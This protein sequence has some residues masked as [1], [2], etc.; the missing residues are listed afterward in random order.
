M[1]DKVNLPA[2]AEYSVSVENIRFH[3]LITDTKN[4]PDKE[5]AEDSPLILHDHVSSEIFAAVKGS[6]AIRCEGSDI[7]LSE[8]DVAIVPPGVKHTMLRSTEHD[9]TAGLSFTCD[10]DPSRGS[11]DLYSKLKPFTGGDKIAVY[12][13]LP[14]MCEKIKRISD[15]LG[16]RGGIIPAIDTVTLLLE[17]SEIEDNHPGITDDLAEEQY[18]IKRMMQLDN[19]IGRYYVSGL[20][21]SDVAEKLY[22]SSR[23][24][25]RIVRKR[26]GKTLHKVIMEKRV[27]AARN[28]LVTTDMTVERIGSTVGFS[29][30]AG[31]YREFCAVYG[32]TPAEY[33]KNSKKLL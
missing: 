8:G 11:F 20:K 9:E 31:F 16:D 32:V 19:I 10:R 29:S 15:A 12:R 1:T 17:A 25:D 6:T 3:L 30:N 21:M 27:S 14:K 24:L 33:R 5:K 22:I 23:Q 28:M 4:D 13:S 2:D 26:Y 7:L 18:D